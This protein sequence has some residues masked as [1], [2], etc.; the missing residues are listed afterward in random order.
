[1][2]QRRDWSEQVSSI[3]EALEDR[4]GR[5]V[6]SLVDVLASQHSGRQVQDSAVCWAWLTRRL[7]PEE[8]VGESDDGARR[9]YLRASGRQYLRSPWPLFWAA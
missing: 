7:V 3:L 8:L 1:M 6:P 5:D 4:Q 2:P 9:L